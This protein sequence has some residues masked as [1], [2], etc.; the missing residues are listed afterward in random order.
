MKE[1][2]LT[3]KEKKKKKK[4]LVTKQSAKG[5][6]DVIIAFF[7]SSA[8]QLRPSGLS[9]GAR[10]DDGVKNGDQQPGRDRLSTGL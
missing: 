10:Y 4:T 3:R 2:I 6:P 5:K 9:R 8:Q 1:E 7:D